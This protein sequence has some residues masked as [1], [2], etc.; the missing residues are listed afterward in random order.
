MENR[1][2]FDECSEAAST[3]TALN[4]FLFADNQFAQF[5]SPVASSLLALALFHFRVVTDDDSQLDVLLRVAVQGGAFSMLVDEL[6]GIS[7]SSMT[8][9][10][11]LTFFD[12][13]IE[14]CQS[15]STNCLWRCSQYMSSVRF[16]SFRFIFRLFGFSS[17]ISL[18]SRACTRAERRT[19]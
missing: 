1:T 18:H 16:K 11:K 7:V 5:N 13:L 10:T 4:T 8:A 15:F 6:R 9:A 14:F 3:L 17:F 2:R 12:V 19:A